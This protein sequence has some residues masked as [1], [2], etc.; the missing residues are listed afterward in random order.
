VALANKI[1]ELYYY[2]NRGGNSAVNVV[3]MRFFRI[4]TETEKNNILSGNSRFKKYFEELPPDMYE[5]ELKEQFDIFGWPAGIADID[6]PQTFNEKIQWLKIHDSTSLKARLADKYLV[7]EWVA[8][9]IGEEHLVPLTGG[10]WKCGEDIDFDSLP[11][12]FVL[13]ANHGTGMNLIVK[14]KC[15]LDINKTVKIANGWLNTLFGWRGM[16]AQYFKIPHLLVAEEYLEQMDG[17][18]LDYKIYCCNGKPSYILVVGDRN[19]KTHD[20]KMAIYDTDW[21]RQDFSTGDYPEYEYNLQRPE[22]LNELLDIAGILAEG[23]M[24]VRVDLYVIGDEIKFGEMT[25]TPGNG[26][27]SWK[28]AEANLEVGGKIQLQMDKQ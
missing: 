19:H 15:T 4:I 16:E 3:L 18:L 12:K 26:W 2:K 13:K 9:K 22:K 1:K 5:A 6:H 24:F 23:F 21:K 8:G 17:N 14:D 20:G 7:R 27:F 28:P 11:G 25:F 10:P